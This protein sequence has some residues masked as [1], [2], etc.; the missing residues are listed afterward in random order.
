[1]REALS[2]AW[3]RAL[4]LP[5]EATTEGVRLLRDLLRRHSF[6]ALARRMRCDEGSVRAWAREESKPGLILRARGVD[7]L[8]IS[9]RAWDDPRSSDLYAGSEPETTKR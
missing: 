1:M 8:G 9:E 2:V 6:A 7:V 5:Q 3:R 4:L